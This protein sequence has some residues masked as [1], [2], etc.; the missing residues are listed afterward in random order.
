MKIRS[1]C[2]LNEASKLLSK[3]ANVNH[4]HKAMGDEGNEVAGTPLMAAAANGENGGS[5]L[6]YDLMPSHLV[7]LLPGNQEM[8][9]LLI[10][11]KADV[12][13]PDPCG[14]WRP[15]HGAALTGRVSMIELLI[16]KGARLDVW[17]KTGWQPLH[18]ACHHG[19]KD[20]AI[21]LLNH[22]ADINACDETGW[23]PLLRAV[24]MKYIDIVRMLLSRGADPNSPT[25]QEEGNGKTAL[26]MCAEGG[27][28]EL[29]KVLVEAGAKLD[30]HDLSSQTSIELAARK[31][32]YEVVK[33][34][35]AAG[36]D[37]ETVYGGTL[38]HLAALTGNQEMVKLLMTRKMP[39][40]L[41]QGGDDDKDDENEGH[42]DEDGDRNTCYG[43]EQDDK[44]EEQD[45]GCEC[46][47]EDYPPC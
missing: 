2:R 46:D 19:Q 7:L 40:A 43:Q 17:T 41:P 13:L 33:F 22:G 30:V 47:N 28:L 12:N 21:C 32:H 39:Q 29:C 31:G 23:T 34:L 36:C 27:E 4:P 24:N 14:N 11:R 25:N 10:N 26:H 35:V 37:V 38:L 6:L 15:I 42:D 44:Y 18:F 45:E 9:K 8:V 16:S 1:I 5:S 20:A 3:G